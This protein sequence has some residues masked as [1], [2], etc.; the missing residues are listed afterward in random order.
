MVGKWHQCT[1][2]GKNLSSYHSLWRHKK[3][4]QTDGVGVGQKRSVSSFD[5]IP[6]FDGSE[7]G[8]GKSKS[9]DTLTR[10]ERVVH[11]STNAENKGAFSPLLSSQHDKNPKIRRLVDAVIN[12]GTSKGVM[13]KKP[14]DDF[15]FGFDSMVEAEKGEKRSSVNGVK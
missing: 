1:S 14:K 4:C 7:F 11:G 12:D 5:E 10:M 9:K 8:P 15:Q 6:T 3:N 13:E 2:C